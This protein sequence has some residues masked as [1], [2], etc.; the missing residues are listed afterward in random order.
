MSNKN[1]SIAPIFYICKLVFRT[2]LFFVACVLYGINA[3]YG[4]AGFYGLENKM[5]IYTI[6]TILFAIGIIL[7]FIPNRLESIGCQRQFAQNYQPTSE[8]QPHTQSIKKTVYVAIFWLIVD[9][10]I[11]TLYFTHIIDQYIVLILILLAAVCDNIS[12]LLFCPF[13]C[14]MG[15]KCCHTCRIYNWDYAMVFATG[16][17][18][19]HPLTIILFVLSFALLIYWEI[20]YHRHTERFTENTNSAL[21][22]EK[23][24]EHLCKYKNKLKNI[25]TKTKK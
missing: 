9:T 17:L 20:I 18:I 12:T 21:T 5:W 11:A 25:L 16:I 3:H 22:C 15:N 8:K 14:I 1:R 2:T 4:S 10:I 23:C 19:I 13:Q 7:R 6:I 24:T